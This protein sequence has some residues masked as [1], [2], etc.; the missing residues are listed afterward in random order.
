MKPTLTQ[1]FAL[2]LLALAAL[3]GGLFFVV[4][5]LSRESIIESSERIR[6]QASREIEERVTAFLAKAPEAVQQFQGALTRG[7]CDPHD[8]QEVERT[9]LALLPSNPEVGELTFTYGTKLGFDEKGE[10]QLAPTPRGQMSLVRSEEKLW[11]RHVHLEN[12]AVVAD[13]RDIDAKSRLADLP[14]RREPSAAIDDPTT[15]LTFTTPTSRDFYGRLLPSELH[16]SQLDADLPESQRRVEVS[17]QQVV[18]D[19]AG[20]FAGVLRVGLLRQQLDRAV[21][22]KIAPEGNDPHRIFI[23]DSGGLMIAPITVASRIVEAE[24]GVRFRSDGAPPEVV[25]ALAN[26][27]LRAAT[28]ETPTVSTHFRSGG[29]EFLA[30]FHR[31]R[32]DTGVREW[33]VGIVAPRAFYLG[34]LIAMRDRLLAFSFGIIALLILG[35]GLTLRAVKRA[36]AQIERES[37]RMNRFEFSPAATDSA[38]AT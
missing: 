7:L 26:P 21:A 19:A 1:V 4:F 37:V 35:G 22:L 5:K 16:Y 3:L 9:L 11:S 34:K 17:V 13:R 14:L 36:Q 2:S 27:E 29:E 8:L 18:T 32:D 30:T 28:P 25:A 23:C 31:L 20:N 6:V 33:I 24:D 12:G 10:I 15:H 38:S